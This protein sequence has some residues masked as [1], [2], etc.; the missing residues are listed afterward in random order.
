[1]A[2]EN[3]LVRALHLYNEFHRFPQAMKLVADEFARAVRLH[4]PMN[5]AHEGKA[6]IDEE[7]FEL[8]QIIMKKEENRNG[9]RMLEEAV[10][11]AAMAIR[12]IVDVCLS[13]AAERGSKDGCE[14]LKG[15]GQPSNQ[16]GG[17]K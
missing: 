4:P 7:L 5:S 3:E 16:A 17:S 8:W 15:E 14:G 12:F 10:Q 6:V 9:Q 2:D 1:M 11:V 13:N